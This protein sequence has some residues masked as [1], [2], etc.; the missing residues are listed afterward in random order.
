MKFSESINTCF[1]KYATFTGTASRSEYW[2]FYLFAVM[3]NWMGNVFDAV[4]FGG[5]ICSLVISLGLFTPWIA[6]GSRRL[7]DVGKSGWWQLLFI[8][9]IGGILVLYWMA[10]K[11]DHE[12]KIPGNIKL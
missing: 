8:T 3:M 4:L 10:K 2:W 12:M 5:A 1:S 7:H 11:P 9:I 6:V